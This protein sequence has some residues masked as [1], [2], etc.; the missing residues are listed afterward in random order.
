ME[1]SWSLLYRLDLMPVSV[2]NWRLVSDASSLNNGW[3][4][5]LVDLIGDG[6]LDGWLGGLVMH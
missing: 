4:Y 6:W 5:G 2:C 1:R 3:M